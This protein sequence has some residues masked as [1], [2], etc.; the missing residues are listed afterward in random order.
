MNV[1]IGIKEKEKKTE[2]KK[3]WKP[4]SN[5]LRQMDIK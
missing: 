4:R 3:N 1:E 5:N 2:K